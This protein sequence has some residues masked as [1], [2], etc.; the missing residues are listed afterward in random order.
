MADEDQ[1]PLAWSTPTLT[2][3]VGAEADRIRAEIRAQDKRAKAAAR[4][5]RSRERLNRGARVARVEVPAECVM[6]MVDA[7]FLPVNQ[8]DDDNAVAAAIAEFLRARLTE[9]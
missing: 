3:V 5:R 2:E 4:Q 7:G 1:T 9:A 6:D 8:A